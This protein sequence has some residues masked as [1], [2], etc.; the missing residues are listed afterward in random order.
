MVLT[1]VLAVLGAPAAWTA[2]DKPVRLFV[3]S[4]AQ[5]ALPE[6]ESKAREKELEAERKRAEQAAKA[7]DKG[8]EAKHGKNAKDW[9]EEARRQSEDAWQKALQ[10]DLARATAKFDEDLGNF[11]KSLT[12]FL[13]DEVKKSKGIALAESAE[14]AELAVEVLARA[15]KTSFPAAAWLLYLKVTPVGS[16]AAAVTG[17]ERFAPAR[18]KKLGVG[19]LAD[20]HVQGGVATVH[21]YTEAEPYWILRIY[22]QGTSYADVVGSA[23]RTLATLGSGLAASEEKAGP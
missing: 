15:A 12:N 9:P 18:A 19:I 23:A 17:D 16:A 7:L 2:E 3:S 5:E 20:L 13:K 21:P 14:Q 22:Q 6:A 11:A 4:R 10:A 1:V 8:L